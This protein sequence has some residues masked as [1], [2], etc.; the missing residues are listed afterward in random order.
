MTW[1]PLHPLLLQVQYLLIRLLCRRGLR[2]CKPAVLHWGM[3][4]LAA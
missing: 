2:C 1:G 4:H 3:R